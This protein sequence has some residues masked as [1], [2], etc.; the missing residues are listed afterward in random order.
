MARRG[1][2]PPTIDTASL[3]SVAGGTSAAVADR[4]QYPLL[5]HCT[6]GKDRAGV[7]SALVLMLLEV[8]DEVIVEDYML[9]CEL[10]ASDI[11]ARMQ[12]L[13]IGLEAFSEI[14]P[15]GVTAEGWRPML[16]CLRDSMEN[17]IR[18]IETAYGGIEGFLGSIG[19]TPEEQQTIRE[20]LLY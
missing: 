10:T 2:V 5:F 3:A 4:T 7:I 19:I 13:E 1:K 17:L 20:N 14:V 11:E 16:S 18:H 15:S 8:P 12:G 6:Q 9:T